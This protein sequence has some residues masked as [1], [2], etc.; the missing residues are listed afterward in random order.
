MPGVKNELAR[1]CAVAREAGA[2]VLPYLSAGAAGLGIEMKEAGEPVTAADRAASALC[3]ARLGAAFPGD[4]LLSEEQPEAGLA[5][6]RRCWLI[7]PID[8]TKDFIAGR[9]GFSVMIGLLCDGQPVLGVVYQPLGDV[10]YSA[11][12]GQGAYRS[13]AGGTPQR[14]QVSQV[15]EL[16]EARLVS[17]ASHPARL[18]ADLRQRAGIRDEMN[19]GSVGIKISLIAAAE[20]DLYVN[21]WGRSKLWDTCA[22]EA[23]LREAGGRLSDIH[24]DPLSYAGPGLGHRRGLLASNGLL[25]EPALERLRPLLRR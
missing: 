3:L 2:L 25:H 24:G 23:I 12:A 13:V 16:T 10:L 20:R 11:A 5:A 22:P 19:I 1:A 18:V 21:P 7:D 6:G 14:L 4:G 8:G 17:S 15:A 9:P